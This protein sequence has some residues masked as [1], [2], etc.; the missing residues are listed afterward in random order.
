MRESQ[1]T[2]EYLAENRA[3]GFG[4]GITAGTYLA[5]CLRGKARAWAGRY[6]RSLEIL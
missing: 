6:R 4:N 2:E 3:R 1:Y 5:Y